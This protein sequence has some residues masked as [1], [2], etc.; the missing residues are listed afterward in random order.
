MGNGRPSDTIFAQNP[1]EPQVL[2]GQRL[3]G[4]AKWMVVG[5]LGLVLLI[6]TLPRE[7]GLRELALLNRILP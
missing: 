6:P 3:I 7:N 2:F 4:A 1:L 5:G